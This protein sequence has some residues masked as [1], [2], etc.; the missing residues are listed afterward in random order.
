LPSAVFDIGFNNDMKLKF[1]AAKTVTRPTISSLYPARSF[2]HRENNPQI[3]S[4]N[5]ELEPF[6]STNFDVAWEWY[7]SDASFMGVAAFHKEVDEWITLVTQPVDIPRYAINQNPADAEYSP[8]IDANAQGFALEGLSPTSFNVVG[9]YEADNWSMRLAYN[10]RE[11]FLVRLSD[12]QGQPK[13][14]EDYGQWDIS[15]DYS[16][17]ERFTLFFEGINLTD[18]ALREFSI[19]RNR[20]LALQQNGRRFG[21]GIRATF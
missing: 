16:I 9:F 4:G 11:E 3:T 19:Y 12:W 1:A 20:F 7:I 10:W 18:E 8:D 17:N 2:S 6:V 15:A 13:Q 21:I 14:R 5:P